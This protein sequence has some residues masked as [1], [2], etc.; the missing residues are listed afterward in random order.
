M[1]PVQQEVRITSDF[2][3]RAPLRDTSGEDIT[4]PPLEAGRPAT[5]P[6]K[7]NIT[8][9]KGKTRSDIQ[10]YI[11]GNVTSKK[12]RLW[13]DVAA[14]L[15]SKKVRL[16]GDVAANLTSKKVRLWGDVAANLT[17]KKVILPATSPRKSDVAG[18]ITSENGSFPPILLTF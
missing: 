16:W 4:S 18:Y 5:S 15:T 7:S 1:N 12:V 13:G 17:S 9:E 2:S 14:N 6:L 11:A 8:S 10:G 3:L